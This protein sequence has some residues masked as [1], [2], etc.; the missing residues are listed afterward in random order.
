MSMD[1][2][3]MLQSVLGNPDAM[4]KI[5]AMAQ[6]LQGDSPSQP[7]APPPSPS[8]QPIPDLGGI[9]LAMVQKL[10]SFA[11]KSNID[12]NQQNLLNALIPY[13]SKE[14]ISKLEKAMRATKLASLASTFLGNSGLFSGR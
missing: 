10:S 3:N 8:P 14:R 11:G 5:M 6:S 1:M 9:D 12:G 2:E 13:L 4:E 7:T